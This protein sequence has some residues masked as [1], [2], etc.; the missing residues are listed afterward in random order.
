MVVV[1]QSGCLDG[2]AG[3]SVVERGVLLLR[4]RRASFAGPL[5][6]RQDCDCFIAFMLSLNGGQASA[7]SSNTAMIVEIDS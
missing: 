2:I 4:H 1:E 3:G 6:L 5:V 7:A